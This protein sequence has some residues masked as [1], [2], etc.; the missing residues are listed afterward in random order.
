MVPGRDDVGA[1]VEDLF[2]DGGRNSKPAGGV[3]AIDDDQVDSVGFDDVRR[4]S[5]TMWR[6]AE[7]KISPTKR[8]FT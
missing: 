3:L 6:P 2:G 1:Q 4:C 7:P 8:I 5:W